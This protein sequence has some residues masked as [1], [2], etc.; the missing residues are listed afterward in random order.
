MCHAQIPALGY[1]LWLSGVHYGDG[2]VLTPG[3]NRTA[4]PVPGTAYRFAR[5]ASCRAHVH[6]PA[7]ALTLLTRSADVVLS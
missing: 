5:S 7:A 1:E 2:I 3:V 6:A 4:P